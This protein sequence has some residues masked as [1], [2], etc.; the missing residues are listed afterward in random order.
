[1]WLHSPYCPSNPAFPKFAAFA[2]SITLAFV[3][4]NWLS[5]SQSNKKWTRITGIIYGI[6]QIMLIFS[7][8]SICELF[9][10]PLIM[11][12]LMLLDIPD[13]APQPPEG[14]KQQNMENIQQSVPST[15]RPSALQREEEN[16]TG[17]STFFRNKYSQEQQAW[18]RTSK[19]I[20]DSIDKQI[21]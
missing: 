18:R 8:R 19:K 11:V 12:Y 9:F 16:D 3:L 7:I 14:P 1:M 20:H 4:Y 10:I 13:Q 5:R 21:Y 2:L 17:R 15:S 6:Y